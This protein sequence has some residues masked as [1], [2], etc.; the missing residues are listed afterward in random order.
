MLYQLKIVKF[1]AMSIINFSKN[2]LFIH[3]PKTGRSSIKIMLETTLT[4]G[5]VLLGGPPFLEALIPYYFQKYGI[6]K[7]TTAEE[8]KKNWAK[9]N[10]VRYNHSL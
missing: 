6:G 8:L 7:H 5:D 1:Q 4:K 9:V 2:Y 3:I 10:I